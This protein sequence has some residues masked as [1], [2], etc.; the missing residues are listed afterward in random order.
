MKVADWLG[1]LFFCRRELAL[2]NKN[3]A[4]TYKY[5]KQGLFKAAANLATMLAEKYGIDSGKFLENVENLTKCNVYGE[6]DF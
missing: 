6:T 4:A 3:F 1:L 2:G 5:C